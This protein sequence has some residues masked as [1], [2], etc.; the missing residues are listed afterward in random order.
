[1]SAGT[2]ETAVSS[3]DRVFR[4][5]TARRTFPTYFERFRMMFA[6]RVALIGCTATTSPS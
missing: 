4:R 2:P 5:D 3:L 6:K 1:M